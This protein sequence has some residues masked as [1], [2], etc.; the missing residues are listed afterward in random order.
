MRIKKLF[1]SPYFLR[2]PIVLAK[3]AHRYVIPA[4]AN[5]E[6]CWISQQAICIV[7][8]NLDPA[9]GLTTNVLFTLTKGAEHEAYIIFK[10]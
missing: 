2:Q 5:N 8:G 6:S 4:K 7:L 1:I 10:K 9:P 3:L